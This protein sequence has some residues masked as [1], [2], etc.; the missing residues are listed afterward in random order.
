[1]SWS[2]DL[3]IGE[4]RPWPDMVHVVRGKTDETRRY[5]PEE[6]LFHERDGHDEQFERA[7]SLEAENAKLQDEN[8]RLRSCLSDDAENARMIMGENA[9]LRE[10][11]RVLF[12]CMQYERDCDGCRMNG[13]DG[14]VTELVGCDGLR[15]RM[16]KLGIEVVE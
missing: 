4:F 5:V 3:F 15:D 12:Y 6:M 13:A 10:L 1:M 2:P 9:K 11:V 16:R 7:R 14:A 8:A